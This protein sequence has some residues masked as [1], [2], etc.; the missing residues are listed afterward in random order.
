M[1]IHINEFV[2]WS[3]SCIRKFKSSTYFRIFINMPNSI[4]RVLLSNSIPTYRDGIEIED[5][6]NYLILQEENII[7]ILTD[8]DGILTYTDLTT[9]FISS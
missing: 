4:N 9:K 7:G 6:I 3:C 2:I 8:T 5:D 1:R